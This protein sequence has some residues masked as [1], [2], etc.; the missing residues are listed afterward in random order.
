[1]I[2]GFDL[3]GLS[4]SPS[5]P[6]HSTASHAGLLSSPTRGEAAPMTISRR[7]CLSPRGRGYEGRASMASPWPKLVRGHL[8]CFLFEECAP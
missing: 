6:R 2:E 3:G 1:M 4:P 5:E 8:S 7:L